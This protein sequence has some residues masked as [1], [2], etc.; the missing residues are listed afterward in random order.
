MRRLSSLIGFAAAALASSAAHAAGPVDVLYAGSLVKLMEQDVGPAFDRAS[1]DT[2]QGF[3]G[4]SK[5]LANQ[6]SGKLRRGDVF[7]SANPRVNDALMGTAHGD[8]VSW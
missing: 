2:F 8:W 7:I 3:A 4:G 5:G 1:G 6:I